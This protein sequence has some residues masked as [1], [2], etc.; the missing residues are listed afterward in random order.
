MAIINYLTKVHLAPGCIQELPAEMKA[1]GIDTPFLITDQGLLGSDAFRKVMAL[2]PAAVVFSDTPQNPTEEAVEAAARHY[3]EAGCNGLIALGG[4]SPIDLAKAVAILATH[5]LPLDQYDATMGGEARISD[6]VAPLIAIPTTAGTGS[7]VGR[8]A[9]ISFRNGSKRSIRSFSIVPRVAFCDAELTVSLPPWLTAATGMDALTHCVETY[10]SPIDNPVA[11]VIALRGAAL[12]FQNIEIAA[13]QGA[14]DI[15]VRHRM[16]TAALMGGLAFQKGLGGVHALSHPLGS[17]RECK[18]HHGT[19]NAILLPHVLRYN[20]AFIVERSRTLAVALGLS[21]EADLAQAI[22][23]LNRRLG[24]PLRLRD[25][26]ITQDVLPSVAAAAMKDLSTR[27][28]PRPMTAEG[29]EQIL[30][31]AF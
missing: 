23:L 16:M 19:L 4:G 2:C 12:V 1:H 20:R 27:N 29:Y 3:H 9:M 14:G 18:L 24:L 25:V 31:E 26:G 7:E 22:D 6:Q 11:E 21:A 13:S 30:Q 28:N 17:L 5:P 15:E 10:L 8:S